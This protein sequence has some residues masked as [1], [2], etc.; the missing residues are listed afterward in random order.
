MASLLTCASAKLTA[1]DDV[2]DRIRPFRQTDRVRAGVGPDGRP[3]ATPC[4]DLWPSISAL[5]FESCYSSC[6]SYCCEGP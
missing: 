6:V 1:L 4:H 2:L 5:A 3:S